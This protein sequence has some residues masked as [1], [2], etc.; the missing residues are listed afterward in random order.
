MDHDYVSSPNK[1]TQV[2]QAQEQDSFYEDVDM[3]EEGSTLALAATPAQS[4]N[5]SLLSVSASRQSSPGTTIT[6]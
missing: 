2:Q 6:T 5:S 3:G 4:Q 1:P